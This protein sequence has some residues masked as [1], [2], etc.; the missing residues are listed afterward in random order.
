MAEV[1]MR[2]IIDREGLDWEV[3]SAGTESFHIGKPAHSGTIK[4]C[5]INELDASTHIARQFKSNDFESYDVIYALATDVYS[6]IRRFAK[7][8]EQMSKVKLIMKELYPD[9]NLSV[10]DPYYGTEK[11]FHQVYEVLVN[12]CETIMLKYRYPK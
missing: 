10:K 11:D 5:Q 12:L 3:D 1:I 8:P 4:V 6:E 2:A 9:R 7:H